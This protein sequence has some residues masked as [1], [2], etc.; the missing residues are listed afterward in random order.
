MVYLLQG[1]KGLPVRNQMLVL[2]FRDGKLLSKA[3]EFL[4]NLDQLTSGKS[5]TPSVT[6]ANAVRTAITESKLSAPANFASKYAFPGIKKFDFGTLGIATDNVTAELMW[7]PVMNGPFLTSVKLAWQVELFPKTSSDMWSIRIDATNNSFIEKNNYTVYEQFHNPASQ[8]LSQ[9]NFLLKD[10]SLFVQNNGINKN[11]VWNANEGEQGTGTGNS[12]SLV[13]TANYTVIAWPTEA[14]NYGPA[15]VATNP[16][17]L[18]GGNAVSLKWHNDGANDYTVSRGNNVNAHEDRANN[19]SNAG[20]QAASTTTPD[21]LNF[22]YAGQPNYT[23]QPTDPQFQQFAITNLF[24]WNNINHDMTYKYGFDEPAGNFQ[25]NNQGRGGLQGDYVEADAQDGG[26][27]NNANFGTPPDGSKPRM[28]MYLFNPAPGTL[29]FVV[30]SPASI[31]GPYNAVEGAFSPNNL[32]QNVGPK[33][34]NLVYYNDQAAAT[35]EACVAPS[36]AA[37]LAGKIALINRGNCNFTVKVANAQAAGAIAVV[38]VNN[39]AGN[40][41]VM[42]GGPDPTITIPA[43]MISDVDGATIAAQLNNPAVNVT[44]SST[45]GGTV[46]LDG[47][48]DNGVISHEFFHGVSN[49][50]TGGP[51]TTSCLNNAEEGG[52]G[53]SDYNAIMITT[54]WATALPTDGFNKKRPMGTYVLGQPITGNGIRLYPYCTNI[55]VNPLTYASMGVAPVGT[56]VHNIG[57]ILCETLWEVTWQLIQTNGINANLWNNAGTG[58]NTIAYKLVM[59]GMKL[60]PCSPG[61]IDVRNAIMQADQNLYGGAHMCDLWIAFAKRGMGF[62]ASQGSS[63]SATDQ[64]P[65]FALPPGATFTAQPNNATTCNGS[66][67]TFTG[68]ATNATGY[69]WQVSTTGCGGTFTNIT[70]GAPYS[71]ATTNTLTINP[72]ATAMNGY[73]YRL[74]ATTSCGSGNSNC[75][76]LTV[77]PAAVGG[78]ISPANTSVC[79]TPNSTVLTLTGNVGPVTQWE[80]STTAAAGPY[81][82]IAGTAGATSYTATN[83]ATTTWYRAFISAAGCA[84]AYSSVAQITFTP[85]ASN[86]YI[87]SDVSTTL[88]QGDPARLT[89]MEG[90]G[91]TPVTVSAT[92]GNTTINTNQGISCGNATT[93]SVNSYWRVYDLTTY[94][95]VTSNYTITSV[96]F[97]TEVATG[98]P[99]NV[100]VNLYNQTGGAFPGGTRTLIATQTVSVANTPA[101]GSINTATFTTPPVVSNTQTIVVEVQ[102]AG[103]AN[104]RYFPG[105]TS[106]VES[107][108]SYI[109]SAACAINTPVT[110]A[111]IGFPTCHL[112]QDLIGTIQGVGTIV[113][114]GTF[115]WSPAAGLNSTTSNPVAA[116][117]AVTTTYTVQHNNGAGCIRTA[118]ITLTVNTRPTVTAQPT[119]T[120]VCANS[121]ATF[122]VGG[123]GTGLTYQWQVSTDNGAT[124]T[125]VTNVAPYSGATTATLTIN[126]AAFSMNGYLYR[127]VLSGTCPP[128]LPG[129]PNISNSAKLT[130]TA[131]PTVTITPAGPV[132]G[133]IAGVNGTMLTTG[134][135]A[136]P[137]IPGSQTVSSGTINLL[138]PDNNA[139]GVTNVINMAGVP[140]NATITNV[141]VTFNNFSHTYPGDI[142]ANLKAPNG[143]IL[144]LYKYNSGL[145]T[146]ASSGVPTWG[147]YGSNISS[148][149]T[150]AFSTVASAPYTY[151]AG[152]WKADMLNAAVAG[153]TIQN[154]TGFV[155]T[156]TN[157]NQMYTTGASANGAWTL[158]LADG[159]GGDVG[160]L[161]SWSIKIDYTT[162]N[163]AVPFN[164]VWTPA[165]GLYTDPNAT[166][167]YIAGTSAATVYA[168]PTVNTLYTVTITDNAT[169]CTNTA[170]VQV[171]YT[172]NKPTV[173]PTSV[174]MCLGD[175]PAPITI[176]SSLAPTTVTQSNNTT[177]A[178]PDGNAAGIQSVINI[179]GVPAGA[180][181]SSMNVTLNIPNHT[182]PADLIINLKAPNGQILNLYKHNTN[183]DNGAAS[184]PGAGFYNAVVSSTGAV[185]FKNVPSPYAYGVTAPTGP[186][187]AD[188]L[189]GVTST[190]YTIMDPTGFVSNAPNFAALYSTPNGAWTLAIADGG[191]GDVGSLTGWTLSF[192]YGLPSVGIWSPTTGL[193]T[194]AAGTIAYT[195]TPIGT[196]YAQPTTSTTYNVTVSTGTCTSAPTQVPVTVNNPVSITTQPSNF[197]VCTDKVATF[198]VVASGTSPTYQWQVST[199]GGGTW[200]NITN[201]GVYS[202]ATSA[203]LTI[204][205]PPTSMN[206][207]QYRVIVQGAAPCGSQTSTA[208][209]LTVNPLP[210]VVITAAPYTSLLPGLTTTLSSTSTPAA[211]T[212]TWLRNGATVTGATTGSYVVDIDH[213]GLY[214]LRVQ[215]VNGCVNTSNSI[216]ISDSLSGRVFIYPNPNGGQFQVRYNPAHNSTSPFGLRIYDAG[217]K[218][219]W[220][221]QYTLGVPYAPMYVD[222]RTLGSGVYTVEVVDIDGN[223][224]AVGRA[225]VVR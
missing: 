96:R 9:N 78:T 53:W 169:L 212:Y 13:N 214:N 202:G 186:F 26:G 51:A 37:A 112:I 118:S 122:T 173:N 183:T 131:L 125:N 79:S 52:E 159:G 199:N 158:A 163:P 3:G 156:A 157:W 50:L 190:G 20:I 149:A 48:I 27:T 101:G 155:S 147:W 88:C 94:P 177:Q 213:L 187:A 42:G 59:E 145:F 43:I 35:H 178:I 154:P 170:T 85:G 115:T 16:W 191:A 141:T 126:P 21:P 108:P 185:I 90:G 182:Y 24:Y 184:V 219:V 2:A 148:S 34:A 128:G 104:T 23:V 19:N 176:T 123:T 224:L 87:V 151:N 204:T 29:T 80:S 10:P 8:Y 38:M 172:P 179:A 17:T 58:G 54:N 41:I 70:N 81:T 127:A 207:Y 139:T 196:V 194:N 134:G 198:T 117:P 66:T 102:T 91:T 46:N 12:P 86:M 175:A 99:Q 92:G 180:V 143:T 89:A 119:N 75:A 210:T 82:P 47:D 93:T 124:W 146:G 65:S 98:G 211:A 208:R 209:T 201:G 144:N 107:S 218:L 113:T 83:V 205:A 22:T 162:P 133:G 36:N 67:V 15:T 225:D 44:M 73:A 39:V 181:I 30:N 84:S 77:V 103:V 111:S 165:A 14:P 222:L 130:T 136:L 1:Y 216:T 72:A 137:P 32:L 64:T 220:N 140:A 68:T 132:C 100:I 97:G 61:Y 45:A 167:P 4:S 60:Q 49:R 192:T 215:D 120:T 197:T 31:A 28:Q 57:E 76:V 223:R 121:T 142:I 25:A 206:G 135:T 138:V 221:K 7:V 203:T 55:S 195:G 105:S 69:Q 188:A 110:Y 174:T 116:S 40:P 62:G 114:G 56:E 33:T 153:V 171:N 200:T 189:N 217:G 95:A 11:F 160:T 106:A 71:G 166:V 193:Y 109:S 18:A 150:T 168:A 74:V 63:N 129:T 164:Y 6:A 5:S 161:G 152:P